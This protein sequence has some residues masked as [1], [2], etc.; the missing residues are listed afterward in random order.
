MSASSSDYGL[1]NHGIVNHGEVHWNLN[2]SRLYEDIVRNKEGEISEFG[3]VVCR[4]GAHTGRSAQDK[5]IVDEASSSENVWWGKVNKSFSSEQFDHLLLRV[6]AYLQGRELWVQNCFG[7]YDKTYRLPIRVITETAWHSL[8]A[9]N[10][11]IDATDEELATHIPEFTVIHTPNFNAI[12][13]IDGT[14]SNAYVII[15]FAKKL[16]IIG[17]TAY[18]GEIKKSIFTILNYILPS[19][20]VL[21]MHCSANVGAEGDVALFF[22]LSGTGKTTLSADPTRGLVG[23][24]E[25]GWC[26]NGI[27]NFE[28]G[29]YAKVIDLSK[30]SEPEIFETTRRFGTVLENVV[31]DP[32][33][34]RLDLTDDSITEN[35]RAAYP[36]SFIPNALEKSEAGHPRNIVMLTCDAFGVL[37]PVARLTPE[38]AMYHFISGYTAKVAGTEAG[39]TEP[40]ATFSACFGSPFL[41]W[42]PFKYATL[43]AEFIKKHN[44]KCWLVNTGWSGGPYGV[45]KRMSIKYTRTLLAAVLDASLDKGSFEVDSVFGF[46]IPTSCD[47]VPAE[48]L[49]PKNTWADKAAYDKKYH[50]LAGLFRENFKQFEDQVSEEVK[51]AAPA[52]V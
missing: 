42:H 28:G 41:V 13:E 21:S 40:T 44:A 16:V 24:D 26:E 46:E 27:F 6:Q 33:T 38:Q 30:E 17:G 7:A 2:A 10:L 51:T 29:C 36:I 18:A 25:H 35:T 20:N 14:R 8:F 11:F 50:H 52:A 45:G 19:K 49:Q 32:K 37:P 9:R 12:P 31:F 5:F 47:G 22:G 43:L 4:T 15:N 39:V 1:E 23:D 48:I 3:P 34:R